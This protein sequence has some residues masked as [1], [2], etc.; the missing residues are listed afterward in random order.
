MAVVHSPVSPKSHRS[1]TFSRQSSFEDERRAVAVVPKRISMECLKSPLPCSAQIQDPKVKSASA[2]LLRFCKNAVLKVASLCS[3]EGSHRRS[4]LPEPPRRWYRVHPVTDTSYIVR[5]DAVMRG[6]IPGYANERR[7]TGEDNMRSKE[8]LKE[9]LRLP[10]MSRQKKRRRSLPP[11]VERELCGGITPLI[12]NTCKLCCDQPSGVVLL[13]C[14]HGGICEQCLRRAIYSK[15]T[16]RGG[17]ACPFCR[18]RIR[19]VVM[20]YDEAV[21]PQYG[22][23]IK[24]DCFTL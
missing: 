1:G 12:D 15:P 7:S 18:K 19:E 5:P 16:H 9:A 6:R 13:P 8:S 20:M 3:R 11:Q 14:R 2:L 4:D 22:Y 24:A 10:V 23:A 21:F 17:R